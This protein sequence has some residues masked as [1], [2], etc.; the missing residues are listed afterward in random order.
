MMMGGSRHYDGII[1]LRSLWDVD[2]SLSS[3]VTAAA[4]V[5]DDAAVGVNGTAAVGVAAAGAAVVVTADDDDDG[6]DVATAGI[7]ADDVDDTAISLINCSS[8]S[9][10]SS[11]SLAPVPMPAPP[12]DVPPAV[13]LS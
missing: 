1:T 5:A 13:I 7:A 6:G 12:I 9:Y 8:S 4:T 3:D 10:S 2:L 11:S